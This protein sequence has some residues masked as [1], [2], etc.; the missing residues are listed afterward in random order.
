MPIRLHWLPP[1]NVALD[2]IFGYNLYKRI[3]P[4]PLN[5]GFLFQTL[6]NIL[7]YDDH[8]YT[9]SVLQGDGYGY[10]VKARLQQGTTAFSNQI[11]ITASN[12][13]PGYQEEWSLQ[14]PD[15]VVVPG[16]AEEWNYTLPM[17]ETLVYL[18][19]WTS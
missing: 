16:Y 4:G 18:E 14:L 5:D 12:A 10:A 19:E 2:A 8:D 3:G 15:L 1:E 7:A 11:L 9:W 6:P 13:I 17:T